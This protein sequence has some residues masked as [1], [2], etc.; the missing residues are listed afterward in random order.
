MTQP[1]VHN[2]LPKLRLTGSCLLAIFM[3]PLSGCAGQ[4]D[5]EGVLDR[6]LLSYAEGREPEYAA[7]ADEVISRLQEEDVEYLV[8]NTS[9]VRTKDLGED[10]VREYYQEEIFI[11]LHNDFTFQL[12]ERPTVTIDEHDNVGYAYSYEAAG[13]HCNGK[14]KIVILSYSGTLQIGGMSFSDLTSKGIGCLAIRRLSTSSTSM[15]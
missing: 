4:A 14:L 10:G 8:T 6:A 1:P 13:N 2:F 15:I 3:L 9:P 11:L 12:V 7:K 5:M